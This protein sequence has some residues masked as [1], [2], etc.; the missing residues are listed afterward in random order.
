MAHHHRVNTF[1]WEPRRGH[2]LDNGF[3]VCASVRSGAKEV[4]S[5]AA[6]INH[7]GTPTRL[8]N[9]DGLSDERS[10]IAR[11]PIRKRPRHLRYSFDGESDQLRVESDVEI[12]HARQSDIVDQEAR[13]SCSITAAQFF[14]RA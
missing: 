13:H 6:W 12:R 8:D 3:F 2:R 9:P 14:S 11:G 10:P 1:N 4:V 5:S 7:H